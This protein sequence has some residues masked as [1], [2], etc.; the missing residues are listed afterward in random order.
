MNY[1]DQAMRELTDNI[2]GAFWFRG[3]P[4]FETIVWDNNYTGHIP[5]EYEVTQKQK[6]LE[7]AEPMRRLRLHR[8]IL[9]KEC[10]WVTLPDVNLSNAVKAEWLA[11]RKS[12]RDLPENSNPS[13]DG[14]FIKNVNWPTKPGGI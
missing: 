5:S 10:D 6:E 12:L 9:L 1:F 14:S 2:P 4:S 3:E 7:S 11:Y 8:D 13:I